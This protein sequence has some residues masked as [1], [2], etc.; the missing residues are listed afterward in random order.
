[1]FFDASHSGFSRKSL[2]RFAL[3]FAAASCVVMAIAVVV[4]HRVATQAL[5]RH[6]GLF[7]RQQLRMTLLSAQAMQGYF[8]SVAGH[9]RIARP[10]APVPDEALFTAPSGSLSHLFD[11][12]PSLVA[13]CFGTQT[14]ADA[15]I[16]VIRPQASAAL[17][18]QAR[19]WLRQAV[20][21]PVRCP[22][23]DGWWFAPVFVEHKSVVAVQVCTA[24]AAQ[25][26][27]VA[28]FDMHGLALRYAGQ[29]GI[30]DS[31]S[32]FVL[33][34]RG[35][36]LFHAGSPVAGRNVFDGMHAGFPALEQLDSRMVQEPSGA[37]GYEY[38]TRRSGGTVRKMVAWNTVELPPHRLVVGLAAA[39]QDINADMYALNRQQGL[40][41][42]TAF[43]FFALMALWFLREQRTRALRRSAEL[44]R[45]LADTAYDI[46]LWH[47]AEGKLLYV[48]PSC[49][50]ITGYPVADFMADAGL[51]ERV[52]HREDLPAFRMHM[53][54]PG[55]LEGESLEYRLLHRTGK[56]RWVSVVAREIW[57]SDGICQGVRSSV[58]D[59][60][61]SKLMEKE[62]DY[63]SQHDELTGVANRS[64]CL[65][66]IRKAMVRTA[67]R[68]EVGFAVL[69]LDID[70]F[71]II[72]DSLGHEQGDMVLAEMAERLVA[73]VRP[74]DTVARFG[75]DEFVIVLEELPGPREA[76]RM[77]RLIKKRFKEPL[78]L[79]G[80]EMR[81][82]CSI[83]MIFEYGGDSVGA[84]AAVRNA[85]IAMYRAKAAGRD[86]LKVFRP[87][88]LAAAA[89]VM[90]LEND[91]R[92]GLQRDEFF[93]EYQP[94]QRS[95][96]GT[97]T[98]FEALIRWRHPEKGT[99]GPDHFI[100]L[101]EES[102]LI[103]DIGLSALR[104]SCCEM[105]RWCRRYPGCEELFL[106]VNLSARQ[107]SQPDL[108][109][110]VSGILQDSGLDPRQ[111]KLEITES[112]IMSN[113]ETALAM[114]HRL[115]QI[116]VQLAID[117]FGTGYS[118]LAYLQKL[119]VDTLKVDRM[120][121]SAMEEQ[122]GCLEIVRSI[123]VLANSLQLN[124]VAEGVENSRQL[125][126]LRNL[127]CSYV[128]GFYFH[129]PLPVAAAELLLNGRE[130]AEAV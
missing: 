99:I 100:P 48:S 94:V 38:A 71:K 76:V 17:R 28:V 68:P 114:M 70:R 62:L 109:T 69:F 13:V 60:T 125:E 14:G 45:Q 9:L 74:C 21:H 12:H 96:D 51:L 72:N 106:A 46:E 110:C 122:A 88:M 2:P 63:K 117:D 11:K 10:P 33:D 40:L 43:L 31:G 56:V 113:A 80:H 119:P 55:M 59:V 97:L 86:K 5:Q 32:G 115:K 79:E 75:G 22:P 78:L 58:R 102:G 67:P 90:T 3:W 7:S 65:A 25:A 52:V 121:V 95:D 118:S 26:P 111:L 47:D 127:G 107:F 98:G 44:Y 85:N 34:E 91:M 93:M 35:T 49:E 61:E 54:A 87:K 64:L 41:A 37:G 116:G 18:G 83:G 101:A 24:D 4:S 77:A 6:E 27:V 105:A 39:V 57:T 124:T 130:P 16:F 126:M 42:V 103:V 104:K 1:L 23:P 128:Q 112:T 36:V 66:R 123:I 29:L 8:S 82:T 53:S 50:R 92:S 89:S 15:G 20:L 129:K 120:F 84:Q 19:L 108:V 30:G 81:I 73:S